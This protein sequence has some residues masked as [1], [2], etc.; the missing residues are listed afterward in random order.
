MP[1]YATASARMKSTCFVQYCTVAYWS[2]GICVCYGKRSNKKN[3]TTVLHG[4][5]TGLMCA[6]EGEHYSIIWF[7][8]KR[9]PPPQTTVFSLPLP[10]PQARRQCTQGANHFS[11]RRHRSPPINLEWLLTLALSV[12]CHDGL[13]AR[14]VA[15]KVQASARMES[16]CFEQYSCVSLEYLHCVCC[17]NHSKKKDTRFKW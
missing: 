2:T 12:W 16:T 15:V 6:W 11:T 3:T 5:T 8:T 9:E 17:G 14:A 10:P 13:D 4:G 7:R 1:C